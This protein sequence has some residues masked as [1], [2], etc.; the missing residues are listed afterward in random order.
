MFKQIAGLVATLAMAGI[1]H[2]VPVQTLYV[3]N[4]D[5]GRLAMVN[6]TTVTTANTFVRGYP[7]AVRNT[8]WL[9]DYSASGPDLSR[10]Y[11]LGGAA[12]GNTTAY[13]AVDSVDGASNGAVNYTL[14]HAFYGT[15]TVYSANTDWTGMTAMFDVD[16]SGNGVT[17][18]TF[19]SA[20]NNLWI[21]DEAQMYEYTL[22]G[23]LISSFSHAG[24]RGSLAYEGATD[25][26]WF[27]AN[28]SDTLRQYSTAGVLLDT[29]TAPGLASNNWGAEFAQVSN[30]VPEP[31][32]VALF[33]L[34]LLGFAASRRQ[35][36][37]NKNA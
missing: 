19:D 13:T 37:K 33:G 22:G 28:S 16:G 4:G 26:L 1:A 35:L 20:S 7:L 12:T 14:G 36:A 23:T 27:V 24:D 5:A 8:I 32:S 18:I 10:E 25:T 15:A 34:G 21:S 30:A 6:G 29:V 2:A 17:G 31:G 3:T 9:G 11:T